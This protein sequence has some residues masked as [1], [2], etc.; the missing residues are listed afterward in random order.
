MDFRK[1]PSPE[2]KDIAQMSKEEAQEEIEALR[3]GIEY[4]NYLYY[5]RNQPAISDAAYDRLFQRLQELEKAYPEF[6]SDDSPTCRVGAKPVSRLTK[7]RHQAPMLSLNAVLDEKNVR[8]FLDF[9]GQNSG[10]NAAYVSEPKFDG[11]SVE[12]VYE[13]GIFQYGAT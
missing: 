4:H 9:V 7:V 10:D 6:Q 8:E 2:F 5:V 11:V 3:D 12:T 1:N 13:N